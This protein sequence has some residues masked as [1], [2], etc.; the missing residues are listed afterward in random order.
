[1]HR[2]C[3]I[4]FFDRSFYPAQFK[5]MHI[6]IRFIVHVKIHVMPHPH[7]HDRKT[8]VFMLVRSFEKLFM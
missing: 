5:K 7:L 1:M 3:T 4:Y 6:Y 8:K 2:T